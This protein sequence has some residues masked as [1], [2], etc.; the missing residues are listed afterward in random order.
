ML[1]RR[2]GNWLS[3]HLTLF[4]TVVW[5]TSAVRI[6]DGYG[7]IIGLQPQHSRMWQS[8]HLLE[9]SGKGL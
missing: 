1:L 8:Y 7:T 4:V 2:L 9:N 6:A 3:R 5:I